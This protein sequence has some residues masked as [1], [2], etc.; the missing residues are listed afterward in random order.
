MSGFDSREGCGVIARQVAEVRSMRGW[1]VA[2]VAVVISIS[3]AQQVQ[4][5]VGFAH[6]GLDGNRNKFR[7]YATPAQSVFLKSLRLTP[8]FKFPSSDAG[9][10]VLKGLGEEDYR[11][12]GTLD[13]LYGR[14]KFATEVT[15]HRFLDATFMPV[16]ESQRELQEG[17]VKYLLTR[18]FAISLRYRMDKQEQLFEAPKL[19][20]YQ[21][22]RFWDALVE[23]K[24]GEGQIGLGYIDWRYFDRTDI[25]PDTTVKRWQVRYLWQPNELLGI[26]GSFARSSMKQ[27]ARPNSDVETMTLSADW[28][29]TEATDFS[30]HLRRDKLDLPVVKNAWVRERRFGIANLVHRWR[31]WTLQF[32]FR[33]QENERVRKDQSFV[34]VPRWRIWEVRLSGRI[35]RSWRLNLKGGF[36]HLTHPPTMITTDPRQQFWDDRRFAQLKVEGGSP[37]LNGYF[38]ITHNRWDND[39]R[40]VELTSNAFM[41]GGTWNINR[42]LG[43]FAE[44]ACEAWRAKSEITEFPTLDNFVPN[45]RVT[46]IGLNWTVDR[47]TSFSAAFTEFVTANDN[48]LLL[49]DGNY[50][51]Q[52]LTAVLNHR[53]PTG[54]EIALIIAPWRYRDRVVNLMDYDA[55]VIMV[56]GKAQF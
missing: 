27:S 39:A 20:Y 44:Y 45:S 31:N 29:I 49:K 10:F 56:S 30:V 16:S 5:D 53:F 43:L 47:R 12:E 42:K 37:V 50:R 17:S 4:V 18:D 40:A 41:L 55:T 19:P 22:T 33:Q 46:T 48:P 1:I 15:R 54:Y 6:W 51:G 34:D 24:F 2:V 21:R 38:S 3:S 9:Q 26:E 14:V 8:T 52:F 25:R 23:G 36:Q 32:G 28:S 35:D 7:Q 11:A 13:I